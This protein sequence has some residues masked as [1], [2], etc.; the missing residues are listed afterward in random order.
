MPE[1]VALGQALVCFIPLFDAARLH[2]TMTAP[3]ILD[4]SQIVLLIPSPTSPTRPSRAWHGA[5]SGSQGRQGCDAK[6][7][8]AAGRR[9]DERDRAERTPDARVRA[10]T[11]CHRGSLPKADA[12]RFTPL[13]TSSDNAAR[14]REAPAPSTICL[15]GGVAD[16]SVGREPWCAVSTP[17]PTR[18]AFVARE[19]VEHWG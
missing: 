11:Y 14:S 19:C 1:R 9:R 3:T 15:Q 5:A 7:R 16:C 10:D 13:A 18:A 4:D 17:G 2:S 12:P 8:C 6:E